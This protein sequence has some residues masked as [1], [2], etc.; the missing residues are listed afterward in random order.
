MNSPRLPNLEPQFGLTPIRHRAVTPEAAEVTPSRP[1]VV[2]LAIVRYLLGVGVNLME[3]ARRWQRD[4]AGLLA[5]CVAYYATL[6]L[7]PLM[8]VLIAGLG[9]FLRFTN[10]GHD[11]ELYV[12][13]GIEQ[14]SS[15]TVASQVA[16]AFDQIQEEALLSGPLGIAGLIV[17]ALAV[18]SQFDRA[19]DKIWSVEQPPFDGYLAAIWRE[20]SHR[21][22][23]FAILLSLGFV[24]VIIFMTTL[25]LDT[26]TRFSAERFPVSDSVWRLAKFGVSV[27]LNTL[28]FTAVYRWLSKIHV[29]WLHAARGGLLAAVTWELGRLLLAAFLIGGRYDAYGVVGSLLAAMLWIYYASSVLFLGAEYV[30]VI[31][32]H[33]DHDAFAARVAQFG[34]GKRPRYLASHPRAN[35]PRANHPR[36]NHPRA[37]RRVKSSFDRWSEAFK[38]RAA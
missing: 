20:A 29:G 9:V 3:A 24:V 18:F 27:F 26:V 23:S 31:R 13:A 30:Q 28:V 2:L 15:A 10:I 34:A 14:A 35:H 19:L 12:I 33:H 32:E 36:A 37:P 1:R 16:L 17:A 11:A 5:G 21:A 25:A 7:F 8:L 22:K 6:S 4:D 38:N